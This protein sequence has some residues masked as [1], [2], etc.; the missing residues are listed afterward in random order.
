MI[1]LLSLFNT[2]VKLELNFKDSVSLG[3]LLVYFKKKKE[4][5]L[6][7][8]LE[9][10]YNSAKVFTDNIEQEAMSQII[11]LCNQEFCKGSK[12]RIMPDTHAGVGC[13]IG[14]T[15]TIKDKVVPNLVGVDIGCG[16]EVCV[17]EEKNIN[18]EKLDSI[19]HRYIPSGYDI[20]EEEHKYLKLVNLD[21]LKCKNYI[22]MSRARLSLG[23]LVGG[24]NHFIEVDIDKNGNVYLVIHSGSR[25]LGK[26]AAEYYQELAYKELTSMR[27]K[28]QEIIRTLKEQGREKEIEAEL[29]KL[30]VPKVK[31]DLAYLQGESFQDYIHD[32]LYAVYNRKAIVDE[33]V[34]KMGFVIKDKFT[35][36]Y[37]YIDMESMILRKG[38]ISARK[39]E[40][41]II[42]INMRDG[43]IIAVGKGNEDWNFSAA[44]G[45]GRLMSRSKAKEVI[46]FEE[47]QNSMKG[48]YSSTVNE[49]TITEAPM[50]YKPMEEIIEN[51]KDTIEIIDM[52]KPIYNFKAA[53]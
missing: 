18:L 37:N 25:Y 8:I 45:A 33:I 34:E 3:R 26:Q 12:I 10:K 51:T 17:L 13:T 22:S 49:S 44:Y 30:V 29:K 14:T 11:E 42:P 38:A 50:V 52:I 27:E 21:N 46:S 48:I 16:M 31:K 15:M 2:G 35:T 20:R 43:S 23:S 9:G 4:V 53:D 36:I 5:F 19:I 39:G 47:F 32:K 24:G 6:M 41:V 1:C 7:I 40:R 28:K